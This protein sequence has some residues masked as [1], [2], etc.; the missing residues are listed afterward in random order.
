MTCE[1]YLLNE[2]FTNIQPNKQGKTMTTMLLKKKLASPSPTKLSKSLPI[3]STYKTL[4]ENIIVKLIQ[5][6]YPIVYFH[7]DEPY[8]P[9]DYDNLLNIS[10]LSK[11]NSDH[12]LIGSISANTLEDKKKLL[13]NSKNYEILV[14]IDSSKKYHNPVAKQ[15]ITR[16]DGFWYNQTT[17]RITIELAFIY[18]FS[19][20]GTLDW[21]PFDTEQIIVRLFS[22]DEGKTWDIAKVYGSA[23]GKGKWFRKYKFNWWTDEKNP[24]SDLPY[25]EGNHP[26][27]FS[28]VES[29]TMYPLPETFKRIFLFGSDYARKDIRYTPSEFVL[30][31]KDNVYSITDNTK[32]LTISNNYNYFKNNSIIGQYKINNQPWIG[33]EFFMKRKLNE[34]L[35]LNS[36][37]KFQ[38]GIDDLFT[39]DDAIISKP[40]KLVIKI[41][42]IIIWSLVLLFLIYYTLKI[43]KDKKIIFKALYILRNLLAYIVFSFITFFMFLFIFIINDY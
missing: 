14:E 32:Q 15:L 20:N 6:F 41:I 27:M 7:K 11:L 33:S 40:I 26:V 24:S 10:S 30:I 31:Y 36:Y 17:R 4:D 28:A 19:W 29:H 43:Y 25:F 22:D 34:V 35:Y 39:G 9:I 12:H 18:I 8:M 21:H 5:Q 3:F 13:L 42:T 1:D 2:A 16:T 38:G 23:H 37:Y